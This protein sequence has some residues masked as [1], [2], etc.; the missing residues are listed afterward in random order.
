[1][2]N[3]GSPCILNAQLRNQCAGLSF[4]FLSKTMCQLSGHMR[5]KSR[6]RM[7]NFITM[8]DYLCKS[9]SHQCAH[10]TAVGKQQNTA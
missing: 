8:F 5:A 4:E 2:Y 1:M 3:F 6:T 7:R 9:K 10:H